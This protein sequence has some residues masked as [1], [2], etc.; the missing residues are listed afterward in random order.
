MTQMKDS[1]LCISHELSAQFPKA[2]GSL[3]EIVVSTGEIEILDM[4]AN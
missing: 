3:K 1:A 2:Y 4:E